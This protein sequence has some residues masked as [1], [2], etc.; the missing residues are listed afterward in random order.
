MISQKKKG[1]TKRNLNVLQKI[2]IY[3]II[4]IHQ[5][6]IS[7]YLRKKGTK[8]RFYPSCSNYAIIALEKYGFFSGW[9]LAI[10]RIL[11]CRVDNYGPCVDY[12]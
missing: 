7:P 2:S 8:C 3:L 11:K 6:K 5:R 12:P 1:I 10:K 4:Y 9:R